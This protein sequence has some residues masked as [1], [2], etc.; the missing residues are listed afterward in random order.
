MEITVSRH[1][2]L[3]QIKLPQRFDFNFLSEFRR[4]YTPLL[5]DNSIT[6]IELDCA[7]MQF[8]DSSGL[9]LLLLLHEKAQ[10]TNPKLSIANCDARVRKIFA[11]ANINKLFTIH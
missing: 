10:L 6:D 3:A 7:N 9:G 4:A 5:E 2:N 1:G 8:I 11:I